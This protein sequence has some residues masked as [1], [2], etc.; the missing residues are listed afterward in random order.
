MVHRAEKQNSIHAL[1]GKVEIPS[2]CHSCIDGEPSSN[3]LSN[4]LFDVEWYKI[5]QSYV[6]AKGC[7]PEGIAARSTTDVGDIR[8]RWGE[9]S[10]SDLLRPLEFN[11]TERTRKPCLL[12]A[13][14]IALVEDIIFV[15]NPLS[16]LLAVHPAAFMTH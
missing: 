12:V 16:R 5:A 6:I 11:D 1:I 7:Q 9:I 15:H 14:R 13:E 8:R 2:V 3:C 4:R 10:A